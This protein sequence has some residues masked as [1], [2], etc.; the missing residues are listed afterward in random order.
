MKITCAAIVERLGRLRTP[1]LAQK[2]QAD[3]VKSQQQAEG[4][5]LH[6]FFLRTTALQKESG[7]RSRSITLVW[8]PKIKN[9]H[10]SFLMMSRRDS[11]MCLNIKG[12]PASHAYKEMMTFKVKK[13]MLK[14]FLYIEFGLF[15]CTETEMGAHLSK[16]TL[17]MHTGTR[18]VVVVSR[19]YLPPLPPCC[20]VTFLSAPP[21]C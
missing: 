9:T 14:C 20:G 19:F 18:V 8:R 7:R 3:H 11:S 2:H 13:K 5:L 17:K 4:S 1:L 21:L 15:C 12:A 16:E 10:K 6:R